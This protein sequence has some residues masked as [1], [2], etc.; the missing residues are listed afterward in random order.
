[1]D[2]V[3]AACCSSINYRWIARKK[4][5]LLSHRRFTSERE[6]TLPLR[7][8]PKMLSGILLSWQHALVAQYVVK[9]SD[10]T[11]LVFRN[12]IDSPAPC[13]LWWRRSM[14]RAL[15]TACCWAWQAS[16]GQRPHL[17]GS[18]PSVSTAVW[19]PKS[20]TLWDC[21]K[22][23]LN[24]ADL[25]IWRARLPLPCIRTHSGSVAA[26]YCI[27]NGRKTAFFFKN[28]S[29]LSLSPARATPLYP[30]L[31]YSLIYSFHSLLSDEWKEWKERE[32]KKE[33]YRYRGVA[34]EPDLGEA[35]LNFE[36]GPTELAWSTRVCSKPLTFD[37]CAYTRAQYT[38]IR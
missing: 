21:T 13:R 30:P 24:A 3:I 4:K 36:W 8:F 16:R 2:S 26:L 38:C 17:W 37:I 32:Y 23:A 1:M 5:E 29:Q 31:V 22:I 6:E 12:P 15:G 9:S 7:S 27:K 18:F 34:R 11:E 19:C 28:V 14:H 33:K 20:Q 35:G 10:S 25:Q